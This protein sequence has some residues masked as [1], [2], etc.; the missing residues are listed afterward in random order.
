MLQK[1]KMLV[2]DESLCPYPGTGQAT[3]WLLK[4]FRDFYN[5][6]ELKR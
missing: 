3:E 5:K 4:N 2:S 1:T 6:I